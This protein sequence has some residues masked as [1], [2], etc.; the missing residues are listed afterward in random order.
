MQARF[1]YVITGC[2]ILSTV[3]FGQKQKGK[4]VHNICGEYTSYPPENVSLEQAKQIALKE[5]RIDAIEKK[6]SMVVLQSS[7][8]F[9]I[10]ENGQ[11]S[12]IFT[13][14]GD[15]EV[16][17]EWL[18]DTR[19]PE[20]K[21]SYEDNQLVVSVSICG[22]ARKITGAGIDILTKILRDSTEI[23]YDIDKFKHRD[24][25][26]LLF[27]SPVDGYLAV[28]L[29]DMEK[30]YCL[31]PYSGDGTGKKKVKGGKNYVLFSKNHAENS[32]IDIVEEYYFTCEKSSERNDIYIIFS[33]NEFIKANASKDEKETVLPP[34]LSFDDFQQWLHKNRIRNKD[35]KV[36]QKTVLITK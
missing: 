8:H 10:N 26:Y 24:N 20:Y 35:M 12:E 18:G 15:S 11:S 14:K 16:G 33:P 30:V 7:T 22:N 6:F 13:S 32:E 5:A 1:M 21:V 23:E 17:A 34:E 4:D 36:T 2:F 29:T 25:F 28:Y 3:V 27:R 19:E 31:L 9:M